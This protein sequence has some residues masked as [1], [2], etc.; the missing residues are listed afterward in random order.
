VDQFALTDTMIRIETYPKMDTLV[1]V[2]GTADAIEAAI[3]LTTI[4]RDEFK[5]E[6]LD[7]FVKRF[8]ERTGETAILHSDGLPAEA[9]PW[10][11]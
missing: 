8:E 2:D 9:L 11:A 1:E 10:H 4:P 5:A 3:G 7:A 6:S